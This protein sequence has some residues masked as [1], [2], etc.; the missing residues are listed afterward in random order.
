MKSLPAFL[1]LL[2]LLFAVLVAVFCVVD[3][4]SAESNPKL[5]ALQ[6]E[7]QRYTGRSC[8]VG[9][10]N[11][12]LAIQVG[13]RLMICEQG[14]REYSSPA[15][16]GDVIEVVAIQFPIL[17]VRNLND[18][19]PQYVFNLPL[20]SGIVLLWANPKYSESFPGH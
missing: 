16:I 4:H 20:Q 6:E 3:V 18:P 13:S 2:Y 10:V 17:R 12:P 14:N 8:E 1:L 5:D 15:F 9:V 19:D 7:P 11:N